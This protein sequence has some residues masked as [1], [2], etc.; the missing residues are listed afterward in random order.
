MSS[1]QK[2][3]FQGHDFGELCVFRT[4]K[5][6]KISTSTSIREDSY[7]R[8]PLQFLPDDEYLQNVPGVDSLYMHMLDEHHSSPFT[9][10]RPTAGGIAPYVSARSS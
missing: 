7:S 6:W 10:H 4:D 5:P 1:L 2:R 3:C 8:L 9:I